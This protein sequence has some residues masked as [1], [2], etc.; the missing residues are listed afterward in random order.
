ML[1]LRSR[2]N[3]NVKNNFCVLDFA[4]TL[5]IAYLKDCYMSTKTQLPKK[6]PF[7][8]TK[9]QRPPSFF[10]LILFKHLSG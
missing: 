6:V 5:T 7:Y 4:I 9:I 10:S 1:P 2:L 3:K 8:I